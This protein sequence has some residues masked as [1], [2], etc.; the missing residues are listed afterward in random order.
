MKEEKRGQGILPWPTERL[1]EFN[2]EEAYGVSTYLMPFPTEQPVAE[3]SYTLTYFLLASVQIS[4]RLKLGDTIMVIYSSCVHYKQKLNSQQI[5]MT[6]TYHRYSLN[7]TLS[8]SKCNHI[9]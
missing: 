1:L 9:G 5:Q 4:I 3:N 7:Q 2:R 6:N 8:K